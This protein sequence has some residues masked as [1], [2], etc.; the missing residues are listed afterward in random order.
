MFEI[1]NKS[2]RAILL[3]EKILIQ[4]ENKH[5]EKSILWQKVSTDSLVQTIQ[6]I[7]TNLPAVLI[8]CSVSDALDHW[9]NRE[10]YPDFLGLC[11]NH[12]SEA[13]I[14]SIESNDFERFKKYI[15]DILTWCFSTKNI[16][17]RM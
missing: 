9:K 15:E 2:K 16:F 8:K 17:E 5:I 11:Y 3:I 13:L 1:L 6:K 7:E 10:D 12:V 4:L 14:R